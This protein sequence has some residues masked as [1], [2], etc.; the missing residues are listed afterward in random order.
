MADPKVCVSLEGTTVKQMAD[1][2]ARANLA[3][4]DFVEVR[5]DRLFIK[6]PEPDAVED[7]NGEVKHV[8]P[9]ESEWP[10]RDGEHRCRGMHSEPKGEH[11]AP[12]YF[13][14]S[15]AR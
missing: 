13:H 4:A 5:F 12:R 9:P 8:M 2:A 3:G 7:E 1:E 6:Q 10:V 11:P 15:S 14:R